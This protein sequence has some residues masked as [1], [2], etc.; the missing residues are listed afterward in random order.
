MRLKV[1][2]FLLPILVAAA[3]APAAGQVVINEILPNPGSEY[4]GAEFIELYNKGDSVDVSGWVITGTEYDGTCG[5]EDPWRIPALTPILGPGEYLVIAKDVE[6]TAAVDIDSEDGFR[7]RFGDDPDFEMYDSVFD[8]DSDDPNVDNLDFV[9]TQ[10]PYDD[11]IGLIPGSGYGATCTAYNQYDALYLYDG[12]GG[13]LID[14]IEWKDPGPC[15]TDVC[16]VGNSNTDAYPGYPDV[17]QSLGRDASS[18]DTDSCNVDLHLGTPTPGAANVANTGP[19]LDELAVDNLDP[20]VGETVGVVITATDPDSVAAVW[21]VY[22][23]SNAAPDSM[24]MIHQ[25]F[26]QYS[27][28]I[29][30]QADSVEVVYF[31]RAYD[32]GTPAGVGVSKYPDYSTRRIRWGV[33]TIYSVQNGPPT[34]T[35]R[36]YLVGHAMNVEGI[37]TTETGPFNPPTGSIHTFT[38]QDLPGFWRGVHVVDYFGEVEVERGDSVRVAGVVGEYYNL[39]Q[40]QIFG[41]NHVTELGTGKPLPTPLPINAGSIQTGALGPERY[42]GVYVRMEDVYVS[43][44]NDGFGQWSVTDV[45]TGSGTGTAKIGD[46]AYY[47]YNPTI[48]DSLVAIEGI[49][50][51]SWNGSTQG[52]DERKLEPRDNLDIVGPPIVSSVRYSPTPAGV[53]DNIVISADIIDNGTLTRYKL[54]WSVNGGAVDSVAMTNVGGDSYE[55]ALGNSFGP[56]DVIDYHIEATDDEGYE[57]RAPAVGDY[58]LGVG[59]LTISEIQSNMI[60]GTDSST[61]A[62]DR[63][64]TNVAGIVTMAPGTIATNIF[65][66]QNSWTLS[67]A[68]HG[69]WVYSGGDL[70]GLIDVGDSVAVSGDVVEYYNSTQIDMH[71]TEA[72]TN[73]GGLGTHPAWYLQSTDLP[74]SGP[75]VPSTSEPWEGVL[76]A[77]TGAVVTNAYATYGQYYID[78]TEPRNAQETLVDDEGRIGGLLT[79]DPAN[80]DSISVRGVVQYAYSEFKIQPRSDSDIMPYDVPT[81]VEVGESARLEFA[82]RQGAPNPFGGST[83]IGFSVSRSGEAKLRVFDVQGR[84]VRTLVNGPVDA[85]AHVVDW[86]GRNDQGRRVSSGVYFYRLEAEENEATKKLIFLR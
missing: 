38:I 36:P 34:D 74:T 85:G 23:P 9:G 57:G 55:H 84:L 42:E 52:S 46:L 6:D 72:Y 47:S 43:N 65:A 33:Q 62:R 37:V 35:G 25:G 81:G 12:I 78:N 29:P 45:D 49:V 27:A 17:G 20:L 76:V 51:W 86:N 40:L 53:G 28:S 64:P 31:V 80:G 58:D 83:R 39:T 66:I 7:Q 68:Y 41:N 2:G 75:G 21:L 63:T 32:G 70:T 26:D 3:A 79:Y 18:S 44:D 1:N 5:G 67:P 4:D 10:S 61:Y 11:Q 15:A 48:G 77:M 54:F 19:A 30:D 8:H 14:A 82:L 22:D 71:F 24:L 56:G 50:T 60:A 59:F 73:Y 13:N 69:I 16:A